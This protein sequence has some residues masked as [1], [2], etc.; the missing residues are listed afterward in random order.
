MKRF[1]FP[2]FE[3]GGYEIVSFFSDPV[4]DQ[5]LCVLTTVRAERVEDSLKHI[6][7][8][9]NLTVVIFHRSTAD[10]TPLVQ[11]QLRETNPTIV[12]RGLWH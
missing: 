7:S 3:S 11:W 6:E 4:L 8:L 12:P 9:P 1:T 10:S 2:L 5:L